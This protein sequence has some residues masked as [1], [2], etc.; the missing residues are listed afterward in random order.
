MC[1]RRMTV[2]E[3]YNAVMRDQ[4][5][6]RD[7][8]GGVTLSGGEPTM[9]AEFC[10]SLFHKLHESG[11]HT[12]LE[13]CGFCTTST[14]R[15]I[16]RET[17]LFLYDIKACTN[18]IHLQWTGQSNALIKKNLQMLHDMGKSIIIRIPLIPGVNDGSEFARIMEYLSA[19]GKLQKV[20][21]MPFH[22]IGA[23]KYQLSNTQYELRD[24]PECTNEQAQQHAEIARRYGFDVNIGG[25]D[26]DINENHFIERKMTP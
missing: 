10:T 18:E 15:R 9:H 19:L 4:V 3:V 5:F 25:W 7:S 13:T 23:S 11:I 17:D 8:G 26:A 14:M 20:H 6:Y 21:I 2:D 12:A 24:M 16:A 1:G 22:Q